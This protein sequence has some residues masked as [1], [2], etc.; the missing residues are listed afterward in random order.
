MLLSEIDERAAVAGCVIES[1]EDQEFLNAAIA[2]QTIF[3]MLNPEYLT[4]RYTGLTAIDSGSESRRFSTRSTVP[5]GERPA[6][7]IAPLLAASAGKNSGS[8]S[9]NT[10]S[11]ADDPENGTDFSG[12]LRLNRG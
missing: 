11:P 2:E 5:L 12:V 6:A 9:E 7:L 1:D 10:S 4:G 3:L 8:S